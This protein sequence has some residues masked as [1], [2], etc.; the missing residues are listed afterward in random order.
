MLDSL[1]ALYVSFLIKLCVSD[2]TLAS[3]VHIAFVKQGSIL[4]LRCRMLPSIREFVHTNVFSACVSKESDL[5]CA[6]SRRRVVHC[7]R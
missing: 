4:I 1:S 6:G 3:D 7:G 2:I 5:S